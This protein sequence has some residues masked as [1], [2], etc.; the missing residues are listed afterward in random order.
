MD[1]R[2]WRMEGTWELPLHQRGFLVPELGGGGLVVGF[3][4]GAHKHSM[5]KERCWEV[6]ALDVEARPPALRRVWKIPPERLA[7]VSLP[8]TVSLAY[9]GNGRFCIARSIDVKAPTVDGYLCEV[10]GTSFTLL[11]MR[12]LPG[13]DLELAKHGK[14]QGHA[15][16]WEHVGHVDG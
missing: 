6:C 12:R 1:S 2:A 7:E 14:V 15:W 13:G 9:I 5:D 16:P 8:E 4:K 10:R 11:D 3:P